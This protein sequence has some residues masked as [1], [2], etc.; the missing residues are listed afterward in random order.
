M[1]TSDPMWRRRGATGIVE[2]EHDPLTLAQH[3]EDRTLERVRREFVVGQIGVAH[4]EPVAGT[5]IVGL[6]DALH[7]EVAAVS[8]P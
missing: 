5:R 8:R 1:S 3:A 6:D 2:V 4:D 7:D